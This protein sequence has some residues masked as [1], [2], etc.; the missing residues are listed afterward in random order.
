M[1][2]TKQDMIETDD[3]WIL[4]LGALSLLLFIC[5]WDFD[6][7]IINTSQIMLTGLSFMNYL[8]NLQST[9]KMISS[10]SMI[11]AL[12]PW[13]FLLLLSLINLAVTI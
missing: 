13:V 6:S 12:A 1:S 2:L 5:N 10:I 11:L 7:S 4:S 8:S 3:F 9:K